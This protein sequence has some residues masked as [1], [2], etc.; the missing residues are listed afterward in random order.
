MARRH[1]L[2]HVGHGRPDALLCV[3]WRILKTYFTL[4]LAFSE[5]RSECRTVSQPEYPN[6][7]QKAS[8]H[9]EHGVLAGD[10]KV[11][12]P[13]RRG[14]LLAVHHSSSRHLADVSTGHLNARRV[15]RR[16]CNRLT[17]GHPPPR[18]LRDVAIF[19]HPFRMK[20]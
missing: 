12:L 20:P 14:R 18:L 9:L 11:K 13:E 6:D 15:T 4:Y 1:D 5:S 19:I 17:L 3:S 7:W 2:Q 8:D 16:R 10:I